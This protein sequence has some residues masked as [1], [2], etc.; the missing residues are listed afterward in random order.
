[1]PPERPGHCVQIRRSGRARP[2]LSG[3]R[4]RP[5]V[6]NPEPAA[7][8]DAGALRPAVACFHCRVPYPPPVALLGSQHS[9]V[10]R[11]GC[12]HP[13]I[14]VSALGIGFFPDRTSCESLK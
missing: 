7:P 13:D 11:T 14:L 3:G 2:L 8:A 1:M 5:T 9:G 12:P 4:A 6:A 10:H